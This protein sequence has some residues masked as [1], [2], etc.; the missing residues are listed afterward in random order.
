MPTFSKHYRI[1]LSLVGLSLL[2]ASMVFLISSERKNMHASRTPPECSEGELYVERII[3]GWKEIPLRSSSYGGQ[4]PSTN[5]LGLCIPYDE[6]K[7]D[8][9][10]DPTLKDKLISFFKLALR[11]LGEGGDTLL[12]Q[13]AKAAGNTYYVATDG[14]DAPGCGSQSSPCRHIWYAAGRMSSGDTM[15]ILP[16]TYQDHLYSDNGVD[17]FNNN[18]PSLPSGTAGAPTTI[19]AANGPGTVV[20]Q[21][22][23]TKDVGFGLDSMSYVVMDGLTFDKVALSIGDADGR[24][25]RSHH[26]TLKN[27][28]IKNNA[29][30]GFTGTSDYLEVINNKMYENGRDEEASNLSPNPWAAY[31]VYECGD[32]QLWQGNEFYNAGGYALHFNHAG[33]T[34]LTDSVLVNNV[35]YDNSIWYTTKPYRGKDGQ[36]AIILNAGDNVLIYNNI[37]YNNNGACVRI[38]SGRGNKIYNNTCH[39]DINGAAF[40]DNSVYAHN[41]FIRNNIAWSLAN[42]NNNV[43]TAESNLWTSNTNPRFVNPAAFDF[44]VQTGSPAIDAGLTLPDVPCDF[45]GN[46][47]PAGS[48]YDIGAYEY[49]GTPSS[50][51]KQGPVS[52]PGASPSPAPSPSPS[53]I[54]YISPNGSDANS[55]TAAQP[56][57]TWVHALKQ[58]D[59]GDALIAMDGAYGTA[60]SNGY[61]DIDCTAGYKNGTASAPVTVKSEN[62]RKAFIDNSSGQSNNTIRI[63]NCSWWRIENIRA[64]NGDYDNGTTDGGHVISLSNSANITVQG[65]LL[66]RNNRYRNSH[67]V[68][69]TGGSDNNMIENEFYEFHRHAINYQSSIRALVARNYC[70]SRNYPDLAGASTG[71]PPYKSVDGQRGDD[72][73][74]FYKTGDSMAINNIA[75]AV[76]TGFNNIAATIGYRNNKLLGNVALS[77]ITGV[78]WTPSTPFDGQW[79][80]DSIVEHT[81]AVN[82]ASRAFLLLTPVNV[83]LRNLSSFGGQNGLQVRKD[84]SHPLPSNPSMRGENMLVTGASGTGYSIDV[85]T[86][87]DFA[88]DYTAAFN[89]A[90]NYSP[91]ESD[92]RITNEKIQDPQFGACRVWVPDSSPLKG[93]GKN[94][95]DIGANILY[96]YE[97]DQLTNKPLWKPTEPNKGMFPCGATIQGIN[98]KPGE[99]CFDVHTRL[100]VNTNS[101]MLPSNYQGSW[102]PGASPS[103]SPAP[104]ASPSPSPTPPPSIFL[105]ASPFSVPAP[106][107]TITLSW[108]VQNASSCNASGGWLGSKDSKQGRE[109]HYPSQ[110]T[111]YTLTC[112]GPGGTSSKSVTVTVGQAG[113]ACHL[114][115]SSKPVPNGWG[116]AYNPLSPQ[117]ELLVSVSCD[118]QTATFNLGNNQQTTYIYHQGY[119]KPGGATTWIP[120][121]FSGSNIQANA[122]YPAK[123]TYFRAFNPNELSQTGQFAAYMCHWTGYPDKGG[124][125]WKCG[126]RDSACATPYWQ[127]Q[128]FRR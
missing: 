21:W 83:S 84:S 43:V 25:P 33:S 2:L 80:T 79:P 110:T 45:D 34:C 49:G 19:K 93:A 15:A 77:T 57:K 68:Y 30:N 94:G 13:Q 28:V 6:I 64:N 122:W 123:A 56:W 14:N 20:L 36:G 61:P 37:F 108:Q 103:P 78:M 23:G 128:E 65:N 125:G 90:T 66:Y 27:S 98:D 76:N 105:S 22:D 106:G 17:V 121:T 104:G 9:V 42:E 101:C 51:C 52:S 109:F 24:G 120:V 41:N 81:V 48:A 44:H 39:D 67:L 26:I 10:K 115:D 73:V 127:L 85:S 99:S 18:G 71:A 16:G 116:A 107:Y 60:N 100:N 102:P 111:T 117:K 72:C 74:V 89:N 69:I 124:G 63:S 113:G 3:G 7:N 62:P 53:P 5:P 59:P 35:F 4:A 11:S 126:C 1:V 92:S 112:Q 95:A 88:L 87:P 82:P 47:R 70:H 40:I 46:G 118:V 75:E 31:H 38:G 91:N 50:D 119:L 29:R 86:N 12:N 96:T 54:F 8:L 114:L 58:L 55:G 97:K 32:H